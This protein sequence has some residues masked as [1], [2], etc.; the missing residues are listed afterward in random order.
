VRRVLITASRDWN[1]VAAIEDALDAVV[2]EW[3]V[4]LL[5]QGDCETGGDAIGKAWAIRN[6]YPHEDVPADWDRPCDADCYHP[7]AWR[8]GKPYCKVAGHIRNQE[9]VDRGADACLGFPLGKSPGA[10]DCMRRAKKAGI[11]VINLGDR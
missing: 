3:G 5:V 11:E 4:F 6:G 10:R 8:N 1:D 9:M 2:D 7:V